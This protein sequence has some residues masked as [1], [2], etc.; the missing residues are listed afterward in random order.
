[1]HVH[2]GQFL[3]MA[4]MIAGAIGVFAALAPH[5]ADGVSRL[6]H[7]AAI[8]TLTLYGALQAVDGV[9]LKHA[10]AAWA[11]APEAEEG[12]RFAAAEAVRWLEWGM[13]SYHDFALALTL[14]LLAAAIFRATALPVAIVALIGLTGAAYVVQ[15]WIAGSEGFTPAQSMGIVAAW[16]LSAIWMAWLALGAGRAELR[17]S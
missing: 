9:A 13:R 17:Q 1:M 4:V 7:A 3:A 8:A 10:V 6:G 15:G 11:A 16:L 12:A 14:F 2:L 5:A